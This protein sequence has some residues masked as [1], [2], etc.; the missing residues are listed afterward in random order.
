[1]KKLRDLYYSLV[2][3]FMLLKSDQKGQTLVEYALIIVIIALAVMAAMGLL[4]TGINTAYT[5]AA[6]K[7][8]ERP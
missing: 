8:N 7:L 6:T 1:M 5:D 2:A 3:R 4:K